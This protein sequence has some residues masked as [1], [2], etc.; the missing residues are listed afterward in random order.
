MGHWDG[1]RGLWRAGGRAGKRAGEN[2][3]GPPP[4]G[5]VGPVGA[6][7]QL[8]DCSLALAL[9]RIGSTVS[10]APQAARRRHPRSSGQTD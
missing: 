4:P 9:L 7:G 10:H 5:P 2:E 3:R 6:R 1:R 8:L